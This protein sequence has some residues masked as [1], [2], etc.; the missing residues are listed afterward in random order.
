MKTNADTFQKKQEELYIIC[1][2][3][4]DRTT[5]TKYNSLT[6]GCFSKN[7]KDQRLCWQACAFEG[8]QSS[9]KSMGTTV[10]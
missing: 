8:V 3:L 10:T 1:A 5:D 6:A 7:Q 9:L 4:T 2:C